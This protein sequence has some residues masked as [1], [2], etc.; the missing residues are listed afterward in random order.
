MKTVE[1]IEALLDK[2]VDLEYAGDASFSGMTYEQGIR[3]ALEWVLSELPA[4]E[5]ES[6]L[7]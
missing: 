3:S 2:A 1:E 5:D 6:P 7:E 4:E